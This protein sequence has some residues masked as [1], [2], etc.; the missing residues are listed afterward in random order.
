MEKEDVRRKIYAKVD[1]IPTLPAVIPRLLSLM[2]DERSDAARIAALISTDPALTSKI[3]K[4]SNSAYYGFSREISSLGLAVSLLGIKMVK[5]L[6]LS[7]GVIRC[8][9]SEGGVGDFSAEGLWRHSAAVAALMQVMGERRRRGE[10]GGESLFVLG[11]LHDIGKVVLDQYFGDLFRK[12]L[13]KAR[14]RGSASLY[15][16]EREAIGLDH[17]EVGEILLRRWKFPERIS[18]AVGRH[19]RENGAQGETA[20]DAAMVRV[21][22]ALAQQAGMGE[23]GNP[24]PPGVS[25]RDLD[26]LGMDDAVV[27]DLRAYLTEAGERISGLL[28]MM[29]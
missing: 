28:T 22:N 13:E 9:P 25:R 12:A 26:M 1:E 18:G 15:L 23:E 19:H 7:I 14:Q 11:L 2:E 24:V 16:A 21:A 3:L 17:G 20:R 4:V 27:E 8:L 29:T 6:A 5:S 10:G